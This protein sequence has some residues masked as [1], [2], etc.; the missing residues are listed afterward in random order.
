MIYDSINILLTRSVMS[1]TVHPPTIDRAWFEQAR[2]QHLAHWDLT[3]TNPH[4]FDYKEFRCLYHEDGS[5]QSIMWLVDPSYPVFDYIKG[6]LCALLFRP[7]P[8]NLLNLGLGSGAIERYLL[9]YM[10][11]ITLCSVEPDP[12]IITLARASFQLPETHPVMGQTAQSFLASPQ[13]HF[14][15][16]TCDIHPKKGAEDPLQNNRFF[17]DLANSLAPQGI[18]A[19]NYLPEHEVK[20]VK[21]LT[22]VR[23]ALPWI[24]LYDVPAQQNVILFCARSPLPDRTCLS[25]RAKEFQDL[26]P[27]LAAVQLCEQLIW[28]PEPPPSSEHVEA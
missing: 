23:Q 14:D 15:I 4:L 13:E 3:K 18:V 5:M 24:A 16:I 17:Q 9:S 8:Q 6:M 10:P 26:L 1:E 19:I 25:Q 20:V 2:R 22:H 27:G 12:K 11:Q 28:L 21:T 7:Q